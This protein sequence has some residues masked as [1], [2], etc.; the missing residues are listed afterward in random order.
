MFI[1]PEIGNPPY[2]IFTMIKKKREFSLYDGG[3][4]R[5]VIDGYSESSPYRPIT[6]F[7]SVFYLFDGCVQVTHNFLFIDKVGS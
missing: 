1:L 6:E 4:R 7:S 2:L 3:R 5:A